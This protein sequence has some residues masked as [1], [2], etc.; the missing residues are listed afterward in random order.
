MMHTRIDS[1]LNKIAAE[2][3]G[4]NWQELGE[5]ERT[6]LEGYAV[7]QREKGAEYSGVEP[8]NGYIYGR[9]VSAEERVAEES[10][11]GYIDQFITDYSHF[12]TEVGAT[13]SLPKRDVKAVGC[14]I[15]KLAKWKQELQLWA[16]NNNGKALAIARDACEN[17]NTK[18]PTKKIAEEDAT[19][20]K[21]SGYQKSIEKT[22]FKAVAAGREAFGQSDRVTQYLL[23][24][25]F[26]FRN[27]VEPGDSSYRPRDVYVKATEKNSCQI[28]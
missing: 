14:L 21:L 16:L 5:K 9:Y 4:K 23:H 3:Y 18:V 22:V 8:Q 15:S 17:L 13:I 10:V 12:A 6:K 24:Q 27:N 19:P 25:A 2:H 28:S 7:I 1:V 11:N 20:E 26:E